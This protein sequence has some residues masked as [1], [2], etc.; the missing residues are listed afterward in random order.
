MVIM[1]KPAGRIEMWGIL[2]ENGHTF[3]VYGHSPCWSERD[4]RIH[5]N[6]WSAN[7]LHLPWCRSFSV[8]GSN[9]GSMS[10]TNTSRYWTQT[11]ILLVLLRGILAESKGITPPPF[12]N[13]F[14]AIHTRGL[15]TCSFVPTS[16][17]I[18]CSSGP[19]IICLCL[20][21]NK[22]NFMDSTMCLVWL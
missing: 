12:F 13:F 22:D 21:S 18:T 9:W 16:I 7:I 17:D 6:W 15:L 3:L 4:R 14:I 11:Y 2:M 1:I 8:C 10:S 5:S 19:A 20:I